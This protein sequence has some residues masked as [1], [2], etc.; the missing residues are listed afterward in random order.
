MPQ[1][2]HCPHA[3]RRED[4]N[5]S[6]MK[7]SI[8]TLHASKGDVEKTTKGNTTISTHEILHA[9]INVTTQC[10]TRVRCHQN[11]KVINELG[12][13]RRQSPPI[14]HND[15]VLVMDRLNR[16]RAKQSASAEV[17]IRF[18]LLSSQC[19]NARERET[20]TCDLHINNKMTVWSHEVKP[21]HIPMS[22]SRS[23]RLN[24]ADHKPR[25]LVPP[26][27]SMNFACTW[28]IP[29]WC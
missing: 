25:P 27:S 12:R 8:N 6:T 14:L 1:H 4:R 16:R 23:S 2:H 15:P 3:K 17:R 20:S 24:T 29:S 26:A 7:K 5:P 22:I 19:K 13:H 18:A 21:S 28:T 9:D 11:S 10:T